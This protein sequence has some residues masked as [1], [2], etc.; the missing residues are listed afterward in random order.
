[1]QIKNSTLNCYNLMDVKQ[2]VLDAANSGDFVL[3]LSV[4]EEAD[5]TV[6]A[7]LLSWVRIVQEKGGAPEIIGTSERIQH[8]MRLYGTLGIFKNFMREYIDK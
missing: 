6:V 5:S 4:I 8:L 3:D 2:A 1:M 7:L